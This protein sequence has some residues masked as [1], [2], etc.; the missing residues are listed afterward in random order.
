MKETWSIKVSGNWR[1]TFEFE[2]G[3]A[4]EVNL[5]DYH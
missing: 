4:Y 1:I 5:E 2:D 3:N